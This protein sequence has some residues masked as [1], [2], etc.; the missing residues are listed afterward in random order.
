MYVY[1]CPEKA[2]KNLCMLKHL[3]CI[4]LGTDG[5]KSIMCVQ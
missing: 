2:A 3:K 4:K 1:G 5:T